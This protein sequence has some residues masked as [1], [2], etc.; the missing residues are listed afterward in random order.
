MGFI[1]E[2]GNIMV[3]TNI[4][5]LF[6]PSLCISWKMLI[7]IYYSN[8]RSKLG[9]IAGKSTCLIPHGGTKRQHGDVIVGMVILCLCVG[10]GRRGGGSRPLL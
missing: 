1:T 10:G 8:A 9:V 3:V 6:V 2:V 5:Y 4:L 7:S